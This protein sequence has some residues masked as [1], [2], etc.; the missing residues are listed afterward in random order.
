MCIHVSQAILQDRLA[1]VQRRKASLEGRVEAA[2]REEVLRTAARQAEKRIEARA[3]LGVGLGA[4]G[5]SGSGPVMHVDAPW[6]ANRAQEC[7]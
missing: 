4:D 3:S 1:A 6:H 7:V 2:Q 5:S